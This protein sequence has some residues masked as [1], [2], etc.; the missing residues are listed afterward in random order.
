MY[1]N[2]N[3]KGKAVA[4]YGRLLRILKPGTSTYKQIQQTIAKLGPAKGASKTKHG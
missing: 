2:T 3:Q 4:E 1:E